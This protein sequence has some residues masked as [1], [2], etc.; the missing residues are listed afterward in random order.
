MPVRGG[1]RETGSRDQAGPDLPPSAR[2]CSGLGNRAVHRSTASPFGAAFLAPSIP[3]TVGRGG[4]SCRD[5]L[6]CVRRFAKADELFHFL[7][8]AFLLGCRRRLLDGHELAELPRSPMQMRSYASSASAA[9]AL[10][11]A[12]SIF[13]GRFHARAG[14]R[15]F[16]R[17]CPFDRKPSFR[18]RELALSFTSPRLKSSPRSA[19]ARRRG[20]L[21]ER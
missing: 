19:A 17:R 8:F 3:Q 4:R 14:G 12:S 6:P 5:V 10:H 16:R 7:V 13:R 20:R 1:G 18:A 21:L 2:L 11:S 9:C 15:G